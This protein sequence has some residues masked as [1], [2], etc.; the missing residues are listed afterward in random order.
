MGYI[1][2]WFV[3]FGK[4]LCD[5]WSIGNFGE[6]CLI[7]FRCCVVFY[8]VVWI[9]WFGNFVGLISFWVVWVVGKL[10]GMYGGKCVGGCNNWFFGCVIYCLRLLCIYLFFGLNRL[11]FINFKC[12]CN[13]CLLWFW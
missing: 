12:E 3:W 10:S 6:I 7:L 4:N 2:Y 13:Y 1:I 8:L 5:V 9:C 11:F